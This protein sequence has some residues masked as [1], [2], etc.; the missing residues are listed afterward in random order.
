MDVYGVIYKI[1]NNI[2]NKCYIGQTTKE[3]GFD[4]RY[5]GNI[6]KYT[7]NDH[8]KR[9]I[10]KY[11]IE[12]FIIEK[13]FDIAYSQKELDKKEKE[14]INKFKSNNYNYGYN[15]KSGG[16]NIG[17]IIGK[18]KVN[19]L[20]RQGIPIYCK[21]TCEIFLSITDASEK[22]NIGRHA[23][24]NQ[25]ENKGFRKEYFYNKELGLNL[26]FEYYN[27]NSNKGGTKIPIICTT[28]KERFRSI[29]EACKYFNIIYKV[30]YG[31]LYKN[32]SKDK[33][34]LINTNINSVLEFMYLYDHVIE[35]Y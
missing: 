35:N 7:H 12:N 18:N 13:D 8:L 1:T 19:V 26:E 29:S 27:S 4:A 11:G 30:L 10:K 17:K 9:A 14:Y 5:Y 16:D 31:K 32:K 23:I 22:Y 24:K 20:I 33:K 21:S 28:T 34:V 6:E 2:N 3:N 25:C 15:I